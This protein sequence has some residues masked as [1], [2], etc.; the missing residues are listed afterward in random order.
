MEQSDRGGREEGKRA[1]SI[2]PVADVRTQKVVLAVIMCKIAIRCP[3]RQ[4]KSLTA[5]PYRLV[6]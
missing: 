3:E 6:M 4:I 5:L 1:H 2:L